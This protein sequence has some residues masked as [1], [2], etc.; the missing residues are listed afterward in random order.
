MNNYKKLK[1]YDDFFIIN[2]L[3]TM[4]ITKKFFNYLDR[5]TFQN[6]MERL[7]VAINY[8]LGD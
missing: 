8:F 1:S 3:L 4:K 6:D 7:D 2:P 5:L